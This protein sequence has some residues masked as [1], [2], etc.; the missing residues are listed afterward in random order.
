MSSALESR[1]TPLPGS[2]ESL[3]EVIHGQRV[4]LPP[5]S[6][7]ST[8]IASILHG[9]LYPFVKQHKLGR[10]VQEMLFVFEE[11]EKRRPDVAFV[12]T[13][14]WPLSKPVPALGDWE[15]VPDLAVEVISPNDNFNQ[16]LTKVGDY[17]DFG[18]KV[19]WVVVPVARNI[20]IYESLDSVRILGTRDQLQQ[21][22]L[23]PGCSLP[24]TK[25]FEI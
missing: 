5:M 3:Y 1:Q 21:P 6:A 11:R 23:L 2:D 14:R 18:V 7:E 9:E 15:V 19:V 17:F 16:V 24:V 4:E 13:E 8:M 12:S 22:A 25:V 10:V 20:Y